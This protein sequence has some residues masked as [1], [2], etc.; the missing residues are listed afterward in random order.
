MDHKSFK[1]NLKVSLG[2]HFELFTLVALVF[3]LVALC[4]HFYPTGLKGC[5]GIVF[6]HGVRMG[7]RAGAGKKFVRAVSKKP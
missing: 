6:T 1:Q 4:I 2:F 7:G 3:T 5:G